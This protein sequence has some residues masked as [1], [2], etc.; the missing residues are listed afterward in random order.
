MNGNSSIEPIE[1]R[2]QEETGHGIP[3]DPVFIVL[4]ENHFITPGNLTPKEPF[5]K[6][7]NVKGVMRSYWYE[8]GR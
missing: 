2:R 6:A 3:S 7:L 1:E 5:R 8:V 4:D